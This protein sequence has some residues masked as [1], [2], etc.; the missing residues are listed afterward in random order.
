MT[1]EIFVFWL[2]NGNLPLWIITNAEIW[3]L[4]RDY[5]D[6]ESIKLER[7]ASYMGYFHFQNFLLM[8]LLFPNRIC[9][10]ETRHIVEGKCSD[11][12]Y[13]LFKKKQNFLFW[14]M[15][16]LNITLL[17]TTL[18]VFMWVTGAWDMGKNTESIE[19]WEQIC[20]L[21]LFLDNFWDYISWKMLIDVLQ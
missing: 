6:N 3:I 11:T 13:S 20:Q 4:K 2:I 18:L 9:I 5:S 21:V 1:N 16:K 10:Q 17:N 19:M 8:V 15:K 7:D 14:T 12:G